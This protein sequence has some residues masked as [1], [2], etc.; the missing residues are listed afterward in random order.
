M[1]PTQ[2][3]KEL[4]QN[5]QE[6]VVE[7]ENDPI[8]QL[9]IGQCLI[10]GKNDFPTN[11]E[12]G[13]KYLEQS[14][15]SGNLESVIYLSQKLIKG[16]VITRDLKRAKKYL[17]KYFNQNNQTIVNLYGKVLY[18]EENYSSAFK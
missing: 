17:K 8:K 16:D 5:C 14:I 13:M 1:Y 4:N 2:E 15:A 12:L 6:L 10:E 3:F 11:I 9:F 18:K 7:A